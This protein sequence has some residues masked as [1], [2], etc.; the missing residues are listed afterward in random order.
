MQFS[1]NSQFG[2]LLAPLTDIL[3]E[4]S[5]QP[6]FPCS[7]QSE[8]CELSKIVWLFGEV[9]N[10]KLLSPN[11]RQNSMILPKTIFEAVSQTLYITV[12]EKVCGPYVFVIVFT[13]NFLVL[14]YNN[15][16]IKRKIQS[17]FISLTWK[18]EELNNRMYLPATST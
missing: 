6:R 11:I 10:Q 9:G 3:V 8:K 5:Y 7:R 2:R 17:C 13:T 12:C 15:N 16:K 4:S 18:D 14:I 1:I